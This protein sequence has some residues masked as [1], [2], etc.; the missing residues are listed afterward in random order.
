M[1]ISMNFHHLKLFSM[2]LVMTCVVTRRGA[3]AFTS[4]IARN[5]SFGAP[6]TMFGRSWQKGAMASISSSATDEVKLISDMLQ[7]VR[8]INDMPD[9]V[10]KNAMDFTVDGIRLGK[11]VSSVAD[12]LCAVEV[13]SKGAIFEQKGGQLILSAAA[14][15]SFEART[16]AVG[17]V[18]EHLREDGIV[19]G[20]RNELYPV[21]ETFYSSPAFLMERAA[22][23]LLGVLEYGVHINGL[24]QKSSD[25]EPK[26]W[27]ARRSPTKSKYPGMLD[28]L[29]AGGQPAGL[30]LMDNVIKECD[31]EAGV[32]EDL[33]R[34]GIK[35]IG[36]ISYEGWNSGSSTISRVVLFNYD[37][38]LPA[39][40]QPKPVDGEVEEF[41]LWTI[42]QV[43]ESM[44]LDYHDPI[45]PNCYVVIIDFL[46]RMGY[47]SPE[48]PGYLDVLRELRSGDCR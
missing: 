7:R 29:V 12:K 20:W 15:T 21:A 33:A 5:G 39:S 41:F 31:E 47:I 37:L 22:V 35:P 1:K 34:K 43:K 36:A 3:W 27:I 4:A 40:F 25:E 9:E 24:V 48:T 8:I 16:E 32:P 45:K 23:S 17:F 19:T 26:M 42:D 30:S 14:G 28:H 46:L 2:A 18:M 38:Y 10:R 6:R 44:A 13:D 11:V